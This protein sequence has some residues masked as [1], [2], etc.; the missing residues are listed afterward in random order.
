MN[1]KKSILFILI[2]SMLS[3]AIVGCSKPSE[4]IIAPE[5]NIEE[6]LNELK[7]VASTSWTALMAEAAGGNNVTII[8]PVELRH[9]PEYDFKPSDIQKIQEAD[10]IIMAGYE[11]F[12]NKIL[13]SNDISEEK[14]IKVTTTNTYDNL[15]EQTRLI[16]EKLD[17]VDLQQEWEA[18]FTNAF[19]MIMGK[20]ADNKVENTRVLVH[21]HMAAFTRALG[22]DVIEVFGAEELSPAKMGELANLKPDLIID[23]YHNPQGMTIAE[24][25]GAK[26]V[27]LRNFPGPEHGSLIELFLD[28]ASKLDIN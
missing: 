6:K 16:A 24:L 26:R 25:S 4:E 7:I 10:W 14:I 11:P 20:A 19:D 15:V 3:L 8:A 23:N 2:L 5:E 12:M 18:E 21:T 1:F 22:Y 17:T 9:P 28:N 13:E 27:E